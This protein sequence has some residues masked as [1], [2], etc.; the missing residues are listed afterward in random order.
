M[1]LDHITYLTLDKLPFI[2]HYYLRL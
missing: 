2:H 1:L